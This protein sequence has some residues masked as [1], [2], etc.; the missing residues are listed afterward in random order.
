MGGKVERAE[1]LGVARTAALVADETRARLLLSLMDGR[2]RPAGELAALTG[3]SPATMSAHLS[4][5]VEGRLLKVE[6]EGRHRYYRLAGPKVASLLETFSTLV[7]LPSLHEG[8]QT[9]TPLPLR[10]AR[11]CYRHL[12]GQLGVEV[13]EAA[14][15][16]GL[17]VRLRDKD[18]RLTKKGSQWLDELGV[19]IPAASGRPGFGRACLDWSERRY[20]V[21]GTLGTLLLDRFLELKW[22]A[23]TPNSRAM[24]L[25][26][27]GRLR[28]KNWLGLEL[29]AG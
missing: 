1:T 17:W 4:K 20:H 14:Q 13:N 19:T 23:G 3:V 7:P 2:V 22:I 15:K 16:C 24:R 25:T 29:A 6:S 27:D 11:K 26:L 8:T 18:Y 21:A 9:G 12:A 28:L 5:L 10:F